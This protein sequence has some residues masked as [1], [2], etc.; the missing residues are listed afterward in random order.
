MIISDWLY[1]YETYLFY[2][3]VFVFETE[4]H[5]VAPGANYATQTHLKL[6]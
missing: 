3:F 4:P 1:K 2:I 5:T 6:M